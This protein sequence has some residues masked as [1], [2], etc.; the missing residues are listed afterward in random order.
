MPANSVTAE[1]FSS[2]VIPRISHSFSLNALQG[3]P[4]SSLTVNVSK[5]DDPNGIKPMLAS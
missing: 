2:I 4:E 5:G 3:V 1:L